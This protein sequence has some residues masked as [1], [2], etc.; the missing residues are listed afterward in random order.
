MHYS[1][2]NGDGL[3]NLVTTT[4]GVKFMCGN[5]MLLLITSI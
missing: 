2:A 5:K 1:I 4:V 3:T